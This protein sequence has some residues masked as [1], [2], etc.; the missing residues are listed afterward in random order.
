MKA[1]SE[2]AKN[3]DEY[4]KGFPAATQKLLKQIR[5]TVKKNAPDA[6]ECISYQMPAY[7][8]HGVLVFFAAYNG[9]IGFYP[10]PS[11][12]EVFKKELSAYNCS[13]G[14]VQFPLD[15]PLPLQLIKKI[16]AFRAEENREM[17]ILKAE[18]KKA[19]KK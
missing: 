7:M 3:V 11:G 17:A 8:Y 10:R 16:V 12:I 5:E 14:T 15:K 9:H 1:K 13:K 4:I 6:E 18:M 19:K 2:V